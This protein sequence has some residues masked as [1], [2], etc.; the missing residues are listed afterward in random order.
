M[1]SKKELLINLIKL[2]DLAVLT[3]TKTKGG[4]QRTIVPSDRKGS[5]TR[6]RNIYFHSVETEKIYNNITTNEKWLV[7]EILLIG[8]FNARN[9]K[10]QLWDD[11]ETQS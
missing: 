11:M 9:T 6:S 7:W 3:G 5:T 8:D 10:T 4:D 2:L 1:A